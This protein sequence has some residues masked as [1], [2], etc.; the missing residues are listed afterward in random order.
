MV[1]TTPPPNQHPLPKNLIAQFDGGGG[2]L[3][4][5]LGNKAVHF[6]FFCAFSFF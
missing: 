2:V 1:T 3:E 4:N 5:L 6:N